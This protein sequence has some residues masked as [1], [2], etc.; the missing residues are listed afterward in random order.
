MQLP[1]AHRCTAAGIY[2]AVGK[3]GGAGLWAYA[4]YAFEETARI[5]VDGLYQPDR[6]VQ[7]RL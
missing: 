5:C 3:V 6:A 7:V 4:G 2:R 1:I